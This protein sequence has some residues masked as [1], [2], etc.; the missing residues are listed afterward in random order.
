LGNEENEYSV[1]VPNRTI[2]NIT[3]EFSDIYKI[4][5]K[6]TIMDQLIDILMEKL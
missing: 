4:P 2:I 3:N 1:P 5:L 6:E